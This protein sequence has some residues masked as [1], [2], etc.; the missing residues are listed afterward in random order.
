MKKKVLV[1]SEMVKNANKNEFLTSKMAAGGHF[2]KYI[3]KLSFD[4]TW[5][6]M[7]SKINF[8]HSKLPPVAILKKNKVAF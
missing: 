6:E 5:R 8:R 7:Q 1:G 2:E 4:L 3:S